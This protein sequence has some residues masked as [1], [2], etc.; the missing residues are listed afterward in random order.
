MGTPAF[1]SG[2]PVSQTTTFTAN[3]NSE[4][5]V[6]IG[7]INSQFATIMFSATGT[8]SFD[9]RHFFGPNG[10]Y[11]LCSAGAANLN[12]SP[13]LCPA[14]AVNLGALLYRVGTTGPWLSYNS[15]GISLTSPTVADVYV[16][17]NDVSGYYGDNSG[18]FTLSV[19][20]MKSGG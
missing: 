7:T 11:G 4:T 15:I 6:D 1:A 10:G 17:Y 5:P 14:P 12:L 8:A 18:F 2:A 3:A 20:R 13:T 16:L 9:G 19:M